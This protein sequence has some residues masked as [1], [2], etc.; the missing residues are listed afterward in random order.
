MKAATLLK[1]KQ[2]NEATS[3]AYSIIYILITITDH[4]Y[5]S[6]ILDIKV[7]HEHVED[8]LI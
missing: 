5:N 8:S 2:L 3:K 6:S 4:K 7:E 1:V